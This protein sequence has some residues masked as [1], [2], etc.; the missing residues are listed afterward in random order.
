MSTEFDD[1][2][3]RF[4]TLYRHNATLKRGAEVFDLTAEEMGLALHYAALAKVMKQASS[5]SLTYPKAVETGWDK[6]PP[7]DKLWCDQ[8][9]QIVGADKAD[10]CPSPWCKAKAARAAA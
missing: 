10:N 1:R 9:D 8:C 7:A 5:K 2:R 3:L 6:P 4:R